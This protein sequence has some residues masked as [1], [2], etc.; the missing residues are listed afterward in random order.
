MITYRFN[1]EHS[2]R[3]AMKLDGY[4]P[5]RTARSYGRDDC[6]RR[7]PKSVFLKSDLWGAAIMI[8]LAK[9]FAKSRI[10][11]TRAQVDLAVRPRVYGDGKLHMLRMFV[12]MALSAPLVVAIGIAI[13]ELTIM[14]AWE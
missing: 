7:V 14:W 13:G 11:N 3:D 12:A 1:L 8:S 6:C 4:I 10:R 2:R 9:P 5:S